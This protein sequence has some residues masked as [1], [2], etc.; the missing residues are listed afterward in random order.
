MQ[1]SCKFTSDAYEKIKDL[2]NDVD[3]IKRENG[4]L[5]KANDD[6]SHKLEAEKIARNTRE[7]YHRTSLNVKLCGVPFH[8][9]EE[10]SQ[11]VSN[12]ITFQV[13]KKVCEAASIIFDPSSV[14]VYRPSTNI[15]NLYAK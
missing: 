6:L 7:Q 14:D 3:A 13:I 9:L 1:V 12:P 2:P 10:K 11:T 5:N 4:Q 8:P 15:C